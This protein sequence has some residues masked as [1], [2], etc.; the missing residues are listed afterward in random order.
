MDMSFIQ[1]NWISL[2]QAAAGLAV[3][4]VF[5]RLWFRVEKLWDHVEWLDDATYAYSVAADDLDVR[6]GRL[7]EAVIGLDQVQ[8]RHAA[9][10]EHMRKMREAKAAK[11]AAKSASKKVK[12]KVAKVA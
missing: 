6:A 12:V 4:A 10:L 2:V 5:M 7:E 9:M 8:Q 11:K 3:T 1:A